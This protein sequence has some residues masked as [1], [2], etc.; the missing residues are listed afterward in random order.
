VSAGPQLRTERTLL[1]RWRAADVDPFA[2]IN[3]DPLVMEH[4]PSMLSRAD[5]AALIERIERLFEENGYGL[6]AVE[7]PGESELIGF[8]GLAP[9]GVELSCAPAIEIGWRLGRAAWGRGLAAEAARAVMAFAFDE[10]AL[11]DLLAYT[12]V[13]NTRSRRLME[14]LGMRR[15]PAEDFVHSGLPAGHRLAAHVLDRTDVTRWRISSKRVRALHQHG[16]S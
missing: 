7:L 12:A 5:S 13:A 14:R 1:R 6:W 11:P 10:L 3:A 9:V 15:D 2:A 8:V 16:R 4:F